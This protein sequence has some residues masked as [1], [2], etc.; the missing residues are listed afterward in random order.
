VHPPPPELKK[1]RDLDWHPR[2]GFKEKYVSIVTPHLEKSARW[3]R[4]PASVM[5]SLHAMPSGAVRVIVSL[6]FHVNAQWQCY[7]SLPTIEAETGMTKRGVQKGIDW[8][9]DAGHIT[10]TPGRGRGR[11]SFYTV[12]EKVNHGSPIKKI[13]G[14]PAGKEKV[15]GETRKG[16]RR[17]K[18]KVNPGSP[19]QHIEQHIEQHTNNTG[20]IGVGVRSALAKFGVRG[21]GIE[22]TATRLLS[23]AS[24]ADAKAFVENFIATGAKS[25]A[26]VL[27]AL[28][29][30]ASDE[31]LKA[32]IEAGN[33]IDDG[34]YQKLTD[35]ET[36]ALVLKHL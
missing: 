10:V 32:A 9:R 33:H 2:D 36:T 34:N 1:P 4:I 30:S 15:N 31:E 14:E 8:L 29:K 19:Q 20:E 25:P 35:A 21:K 12:A 11:A 5:Q 6:C 13:K 18:E 16:E 7:P 28:V 27:V 3:G 23:V 24:E 17:G 26:A 22:A